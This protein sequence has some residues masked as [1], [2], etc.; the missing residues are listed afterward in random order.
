M[1]SIR[2]LKTE[3]RKRHYE[4]ITTEEWAHHHRWTWWRFIRE[5]VDIVLTTLGGIAITIL[6]LVACFWN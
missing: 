2:K 1:K 5:N 6:F 3:Y 4:L